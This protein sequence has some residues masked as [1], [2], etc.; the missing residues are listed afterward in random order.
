MMSNPTGKFNFLSS[1]EIQL[2]TLVMESGAP[3]FTS[4]KFGDRIFACRSRFGAAIGATAAIERF[5]FK[6]RYKCS[7]GINVAAI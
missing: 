3:G 1:V 2:Q 7:H 4:C 5:V 6:S